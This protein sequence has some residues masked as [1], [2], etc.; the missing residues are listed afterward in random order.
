VVAA[1]E[2]IVHLKEGSGAEISNQS[3]MIALRGGV[4]K[5]RLSHTLE[6]RYAMNSHISRRDFSKLVVAVSLAGPA[7]SSAQAQPGEG[8]KSQIIDTH[9]HLWDLSRFELPWLR[10]NQYQALRRDHSLNDYWKAA[11]GTNIVKTIYMEVA[12]SPDQQQAEA[13]HVIALSKDPDNRMAGA[14]V[15]G[16]PESSGFAQ[17]VARLKQSKSIKGIRA[18]IRG[19]ETKS[20]FELDK[21]FVAGVRMLGEYGLSFDFDLPADQLSRGA[22]LAD[23]APETR[24]I[25]DHCGNFN[26]RGS[27]ADAERWKRNIADV[28]KRRHVV[29]KISGFITSAGRKPRADEIAP[30]VDHVYESFGPDRVMFASDWPVCTMVMPLAEWVGMLREVVT[31]RPAPVQAKLFHDNAAKFYGV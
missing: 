3:I 25:L 20:G 22:A 1:A 29:C 19:N 30:V 2:D 8:A 28:A 5:S 6:G 24:F 23:Q 11:Q 26:L 7:A 13:D 16:Q 17:Y 9:Q 12:V 31:D 15:G 21:K 14:V 4:K 18:S 10:D 27:R